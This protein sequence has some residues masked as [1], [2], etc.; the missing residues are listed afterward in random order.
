MWYKKIW[1]DS[2]VVTVPGKKLTFVLET[3][4]TLI[5]ISDLK[6]QTINDKKKF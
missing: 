4:P 2:F 1:C 3:E 6:S 5:T